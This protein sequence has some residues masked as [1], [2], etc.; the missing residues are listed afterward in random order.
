MASRRP[1]PNGRVAT[2]LMTRAFGLSALLC[3]AALAFSQGLVVCGIIAACAAGLAGAGLAASARAGDRAM[4]AFVEG[5]PGS[6]ADWPTPQGGDFP[7]LTA[8]I[9]RAK[10][11]MLSRQTAS[12]ARHDF[13]RALANAVPAALVVVAD[14]GAVRPA[15][16]AGAR[17]LARLSPDQRSRIARLAP[18]G[19]DIAMLDQGDAWF[20]TASVF[21]TRSAQHR[22]VALQRIT[23]ELD[24]VQ[25]KAWSDVT[26][27][28]AHELLNSLTAICSLAESS[29]AITRRDGAYPRALVEAIAT[30][31][32]RGAGL[33]SFV[34]RYRSVADFPKPERA[35]LD[36]AALAKGLA[37]IALAMASERGVRFELRHIGR[38]LPIEGDG[39]LLEQ[40]TLNL[41]KNAVEAVEPGRG[42]VTL[43]THA[44]DTE[45]VLEVRDNGTGLSEMVLENLFVPFVTTKPQ[46]SGIG[47]SLAHRTAAAHRGK[48][49]Y[50]QPEMGSGAVFRLRLPLAEP[51]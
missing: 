42:Q 40:A 31:E 39:D 50:A 27:V 16:G 23:G 5:L 51:T 14:D 3:L 32:A 26:R 47:L 6:G 36:L 11:L 48:L 9:A 25:Q 18:P 8:A 38:A 22:L 35:R 12:E 41:I 45:A 20:M 19:A 37:P 2:R 13:D 24:A 49:E 34:E 7:E 33:M 1:A 28:L 4:A 30:I 44:H 17:L 10:A 29:L 15:N 46:G 21:A 43:V